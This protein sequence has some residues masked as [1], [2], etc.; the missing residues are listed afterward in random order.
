[1]RPRRVAAEF[2]ILAFSC[3]GI[4]A[5]SMRPRRVAAEYRGLVDLAKAQLRRFNEAAASRR[6]T[7]GGK[8]E[9][10]AG[11]ACFNEAAASRRGNRQRRFIANAPTSRFNEAAA[12]R[13][14][15]RL[16]PATVIAGRM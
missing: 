13:R 5:A 6:G 10:I 4:V 9:Q 16:E 3:D 2:R 14:G 11:R 12:S 1:M 8:T 7:R 15:N